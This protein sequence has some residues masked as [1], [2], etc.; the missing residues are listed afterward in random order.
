MCGSAHFMQIQSAC[1]SGIIY[2]P[3]LS[4]ALKLRKLAAP[5]T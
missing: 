2:L 1:T 5:K 3:T 4:Q